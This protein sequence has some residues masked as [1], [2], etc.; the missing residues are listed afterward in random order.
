MKH[1]NSGKDSNEVS[2]ESG[3]DA[4]GGI[5]SIVVGGDELDVDR[6][7][8]NVLLDTEEHSL[9]I[10]FSARSASR[11]QY[12]DDF[13]ERLYHGSIGARRHGPN[14]DCIKDVDV[15]NKHV[16]HTFDG[17]DRQGTSDVGIH[18][19]CYGIGKR[20][21]AEHIL[22]ST[23]FLRGKHTINLGTSGNNIGLHIVRGGCIGLVLAHVSLVSSVLSLV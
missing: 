19:A 5:G 1:I 2:L 9:S 18:G 16:L 7:K 14:N 22:H 17:A 3:D 4:F 6:F 20:G 21:K 23:D 15:G 11:F 8:P 10:T 13:G 12:G